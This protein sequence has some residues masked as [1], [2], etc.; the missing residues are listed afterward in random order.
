M[1]KKSIVTGLSAFVLF[2]IILLSGCLT[3]QKPVDVAIEATT[4]F[5]R[6][7]LMA[8]A[9][10]PPKANLTLAGTEIPVTVNL[11]KEGST[12]TVELKK[13]DEV[14]EEEVYLDLNDSFQFMEGAGDVFAPAIPLIEYPGHQGETKTWEGVVNGTPARAEINT[15]RT[16]YYG[17]KSPVDALEVRIRLAIELE[18][19]K[20]SSRELRFVIA[21]EMGVVQRSFGAASSREP[22]E[23]K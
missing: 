18:P 3:R 15:L 5:S 4:L 23:V 11:Q 6:A 1:S 17:L 16:R 21:P 8:S 22:A 19:D 14:F 10:P 7:D 9:P 20:S 13:D 12:V 2:Q